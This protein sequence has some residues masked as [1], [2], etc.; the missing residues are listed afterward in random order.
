MR[1]DQ[2]YLGLQLC[3]ELLLDRPLHL[4]DQLSDIRRGGTAG[5]DE[6]VRVHG[7]DLGAPHGES[8]E[9]RG[10]DQL[11]RRPG[12][13]LLFPAG[14]R[15]ILEDA[16]AARLIE[17]G[18]SLPPLEHLRDG[19]VEVRLFFLAQPHGDVEHDPPLQ[20]APAVGEGNLRPL[21]HRVLPARIHHRHP[22][23][24]FGPVSPVTPGVHVDASTHRPW[25][26]DE[27]VQAGESCL[28]GTAGGEWR[29]KPGANSPAVPIRGNAIETL[30]QSNDQRVQPSVGQQDVGSQPNGEP[31]HARF[32][33][34][35]QR[36]ADVSRCGG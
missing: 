24:H 33:S 25:Y 14:T 26:T 15:G 36:R 6:I 34:Q 32:G 4:L 13:V 2:L 1:S 28:G 8:L 27:D 5:V 23:D 7:R 12:P 3:S 19:L 35:R 21:E 18:A 11:A 29:G 16:A 30:S 20:P 17:R 9:A 10:L 31:G 22:L